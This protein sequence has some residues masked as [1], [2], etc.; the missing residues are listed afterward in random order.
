LE[1]G[2]RMQEILKQPQYQ[3]ME[4][5]EQVIVLMAGTSGYADKVPVEKISDWQTDLLRYM[6]ASHPEINKEIIQKKAVSDELREKMNQ[7]FKTFA[8]SWTE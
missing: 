2:Q 8:N 5:E 1:R 4:F 7:A 3:P 6:N